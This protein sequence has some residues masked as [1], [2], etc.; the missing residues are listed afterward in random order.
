MKYKTVTGLSFLLA[1]ILITATN[2]QGA[3]AMDEQKL[4]DNLYNAVMDVIKNA[5]MLTPSNTDTTTTT[6]T[7]LPPTPTIALP[8]ELVGRN[9]TVMAPFPK[10]G[11]TTSPE[12]EYIAKAETDSRY[13]PYMYLKDGALVFHTPAGGLHTA[14]SKY[15]R[16][17]LREMT[18]ENWTEASWSNKNGTHTLEGDYSITHNLVKRPQ[19]VFAQVHTP[20]DDLWEAAYDSGKL[21]VFYENKAKVIELDPAYVLGTKFSFKAVGHDGVF[22]VYYNGELKGTVPKSASGLYMKSGNYLQSNVKDWGEAPDAYGEVTMY[23]LKI[24][25]R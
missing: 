2:A 11:S 10:V 8:S 22:D 24:T 6:T 13:T 7:T 23:D 5:T 16:T 20:S 3:R 17:E 1:V 15:P 9:W 25:H 18:D 21:V 4:K 14:N 12:N 19:L